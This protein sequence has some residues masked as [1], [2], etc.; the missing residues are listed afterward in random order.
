MD[1]NTEIIG[2]CPKCKKVFSIPKSSLIVEKPLIKP[3]KSHNILAK[4]E[5]GDYQILGFS[6][7]NDYDSGTP[8]DNEFIDESRIQEEF[9]EM[10]RNGW[11]HNYEKNLLSIFSLKNSNSS[12]S[13]S[14]NYLPAIARPINA[15]KYVLDNG[16]AKPGFEKH[17]FNFKGRIGAFYVND[18]SITFISQSE[19]NDASLEK[20]LNSKDRIAHDI[21]LKKQKELIEKNQGNLG[22]ASARY[23]NIKIKFN[24]IDSQENIHSIKALQDMSYNSNASLNA[25][26]NEE[27]HFKKLKKT[28]E[29][30][31]TA[32][33]MSGASLSLPASQL[34]FMG[35]GMLNAFN[36]LDNIKASII[37][38]DGGIAPLYNDFSIFSGIAIACALTVPL[39]FA[40]SY[41]ILKEMD[42]KLKNASK[43][44]LPDLKK[45]AVGKYEIEFN[46]I[47]LSG[48]IECEKK[49]NDNQALLEN[50]LKEIN[51]KKSSY[52]L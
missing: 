11:I 31:A 51:S 15:D 25:G 18:D 43:R 40:F 23:K 27:I 12:G 38:G 36:A 46:P 34:I 9:S 16:L 37:S 7:Q 30:F 8:T 10:L 47:T 5:C 50:I 17:D 19:Q 1:F 26:A 4:P 13:S 52:N 41:H 42:K 48:E 29:A 2:A 44:P 49:I 22:A 32:F 39:G 20:I 28:P 24:Y 33:G 21:I 45:K 14:I 6:R 3:G 35:Y